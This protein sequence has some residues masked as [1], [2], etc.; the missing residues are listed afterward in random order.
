METS[1]KRL[2]MEDGGMK[3]G[4]EETCK[5]KYAKHLK[6]NLQ[7]KT[8]ACRIGLGRLRRGLFVISGSAVL[9]PVLSPKTATRP[10]LQGRLEKILGLHSAYKKLNY[11]I[12]LDNSG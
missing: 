3:C 8:L 4:L 12:C 1:A 9:F 2:I 7:D 10:V 11:N 6:N 5:T